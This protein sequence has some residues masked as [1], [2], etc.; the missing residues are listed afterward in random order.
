MAVWHGFRIM[1]VQI[2]L[3]VLHGGRLVFPLFRVRSPRLRNP[4]TDLLPGT[5]LV[6]FLHL[7]DHQLW[8]LS[9]V[10]WSQDSSIR[11]ENENPDCFL[12]LLFLLPAISILMAIKLPCPP[13]SLLANVFNSITPKGNNPHSKACAILKTHECLIRAN[14]G[15]GLYKLQKACVFYV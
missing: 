3:N 12:C 9:K 8:K 13:L 1:S 14:R 11:V 6:Y 7:P 5:P 4:V 2:E 10:T 15:F